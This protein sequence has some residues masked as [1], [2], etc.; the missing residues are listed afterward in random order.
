[1]LISPLTNQE[2]TDMFKAVNL[3]DMLSRFSVGV[4]RALLH[5]GW[6]PTAGMK[7]GATRDTSRSSEDLM[8]VE[9]KAWACALVLQSHKS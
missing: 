1:M 4:L 2:F 7:D 8:N 9:S 3:E 5:T 6:L